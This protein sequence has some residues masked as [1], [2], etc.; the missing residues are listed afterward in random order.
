MTVTRRPPFKIPRS[1]LVVIHTPALDVLLIER[2][3][4]PGLWQS[5]TGSL[6]AEDLAHER[7]SPARGHGRADVSSRL[8]SVVAQK[9]PAKGNPNLQRD[10]VEVMERESKQVRSLERFLAD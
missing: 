4:R 8:Q 9:R 3:D 7:R 6:D 5:V 10:L 1:V 2:A